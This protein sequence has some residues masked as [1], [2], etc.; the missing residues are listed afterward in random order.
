MQVTKHVAAFSNCNLRPIIPRNHETSLLK[1]SLS[2]FWKI[3]ITPCAVFVLKIGKREKERRKSLVCDKQSIQTLV[4]A[5]GY[6]GDD[7]KVA[8]FNREKQRTETFFI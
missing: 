7:G 5:P 1:H 4:P 8:G 6:K 2:P 3:I